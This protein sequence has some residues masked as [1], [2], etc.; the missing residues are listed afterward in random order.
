V[1]GDHSRL[2]AGAIIAQLSYAIAAKTSP[3]A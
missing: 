2:R 1:P 3:A